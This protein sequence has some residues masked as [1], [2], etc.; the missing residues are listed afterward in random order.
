M[1]W[2]V[3]TTGTFGGGWSD[4]H[5]L[6]RAKQLLQPS[7]NLHSFFNDGFL[8]AMAVRADGIEQFVQEQWGTHIGDLTFV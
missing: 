7:R 1:A 3:F 8:P 6:G 2:I 5:W 4:L